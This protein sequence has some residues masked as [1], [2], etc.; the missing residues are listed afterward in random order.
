[1]TKVALQVHDDS[2]APVFIK[3]DVI[4]VDVQCNVCSELT[5]SFVNEKVIYL[6][7][8]PASQHSPV[9]GTLISHHRYF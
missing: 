4:V 8:T 3:G 1:M 6:A 5:I 2:L 7:P 9:V